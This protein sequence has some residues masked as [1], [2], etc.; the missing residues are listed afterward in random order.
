MSHDLAKSDAGS[1]ARRSIPWV[2]YLLIWAAA[3][4]L[5]GSGGLAFI[6]NMI[7]DWRFQVAKRPATGN[8]ILVEIDANSL[9]S[10]DTWPW[11]RRYHA[12]VVDRLIAAGAERIAIDVDFS[13]NSNPEDDARFAESLARAGNRVILPASIQPTT[14]VGGFKGYTTTLPLKAFRESVTLGSIV[15]HPEKDSV[16]RNLHSDYRVGGARLPTLAM[17][18]AEPKGARSTS[19]AIDYGIDLN[20]IPRLSFA[21]VLNDQFDPSVIKGKR[22]LIGGTA[23]ELGDHFPVPVYL[24]LPGAL[25][26]ALGYESLT[27]DRALLRPAL[28]PTVVLLLIL[29]VI[30]RYCFTG[31]KLR[32]GL[33]IF[34][35]AL[36]GAPLVSLA[37]QYT[38]PVQVDVASW[39]LIFAA[40]FV[41]ELTR[42]I[43]RQSIQLV[44]QNKKLRRNDMMMRHIVDNSSVGILTF[45]LDGVIESVNPAAQRMFDYNAD[46]LISQ[47]I[48][49]LLSDSRQREN[50]QDLLTVSE[51]AQELTGMR[52]DG[53]SFPIETNINLVNF[54][55]RQ[56]CTI[57]VKDLTERNQNQALV[58]QA[59]HDALTGLP[60]RKKFYDSLESA[61]AESELSGSM[62]GV[63]LLDLDRFKTVNDTLGH[64][65]GDRLLQ[66]LSRRTLE[67]MPENAVFARIGG[68]EF[69]ILLRDLPS[70]TTAKNLARFVIDEVERPFIVDGADLNVGGSIGIAVYPQHGETAEQLFQRSDMA[71]YRAKRERSGVALYCPKTDPNSLRNLSYTSELRQ[72]I[73]NDELALAFQP[74]LDL[75]TNTLV[76]VEALVRW[77][78][79]DQ[80]VVSPDEFVEHAEQFGLMMPL[81]QWVL[82]AALA[83]G[84]AWRRQGLDLNIAINLSARLLHHANLIPTIR[85]LLSNWDYPANRLTIEVTEGAL[86][87]N[88]EGAQQAGQD[89]TDIGV[90]LSIDDFGTGYSSIAYL[91]TLSAKEIKID[92]SFILGIDESHEDHTIVR[93]VV[94]MAHELGMKVVAEGVETEQTLSMLHN[95]GCDTGQGFLMGR[96]MSPV[97]FKAWLRGNE[98]VNENSGSLQDDTQDAIPRVIDF[99]GDY[100]NPANRRLKAIG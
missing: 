30:A 60:N 65:A 95:L 46:D 55:G 51:N 27:Q 76:G 44:M 38:Q 11:P 40:A 50:I 47:N 21:E 45:D 77:V 81:T 13:A 34:G 52:R 32:R 3:A 70:V 57:F 87:L 1:R 66:M 17:R 43:D 78:R 35:M 89:L 99:I 10:L 12:E 67:L 28:I 31:A 83:Q 79:L 97:E 88:P 2:P 96:P 22:V 73:E 33:F 41:F 5:Y 49:K 64:I 100:A 59:T 48:S 61:I 85:N 20:T 91:K 62:L 71:M 19:F 14:R 18:L 26:H 15:V 84:S 29:T 80:G 75:Q 8:L 25:I 54:I 92:K 53:S 37:I 16:I 24:S 9:S 82:N 68:D 72:A 56:I 74:K 94:A 86:L 6:D 42:Q 36:T 4:F 7:A 58:H 69:A 39:M 90:N 23:A 98:S 63:F 93:S